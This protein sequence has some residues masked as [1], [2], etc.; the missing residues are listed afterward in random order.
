M[1]EREHYFLK[2]SEECAEVQ[3]AISKILLFG[4][5]DIYP[6]TGEP[7]IE[8]LRR[9]IIDL[10]GVIALLRDLKMLPPTD[11]YGQEAKKHKVR[12][13]LAYAEGRGVIHPEKKDIWPPLF[14]PTSKPVGSIPA[15]LLS[16]VWCGYEYEWIDGL[17]TLSH[18][19]GWHRRSQYH[20][21]QA[22]S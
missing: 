20:E 2:L 4:E 18:T 19:T 7:V 1:T 15:G 12:T 17:G 21:P 13:Y 3:Q 10:E 8:A 11:P 5:G 16:M 6:K 22:T 14:V 9:E